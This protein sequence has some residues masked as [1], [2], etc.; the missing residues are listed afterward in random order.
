MD[1]LKNNLINNQKV[2]L[3]LFF[4]KQIIIRV[5]LWSVGQTNQDTCRCYISG[6]DF[7]YFFIFYYFCDI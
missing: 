1:E 4:L 2:S 5:M 3:R 6:T 7:I